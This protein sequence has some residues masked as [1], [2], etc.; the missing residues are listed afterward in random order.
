[1]KC[2]ARLSHFFCNVQVSSTLS[3]IRSDFQFFVMIVIDF[4]PTPTTQPHPTLNR[5]GQGLGTHP[6]WCLQGW[7]IPIGWRGASWT[8][9]HLWLQAF[10]QWAWTGQAISKY[11]NMSSKVL[12]N[13][14]TLIWFF[15][16]A[17]CV[18]SYFQELLLKR[19]CSLL[20]VAINA[21][22]DPL[23]S[24]SVYQCTWNCQIR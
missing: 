24:M 2:I 3:S 11:M 20:Q 8:L 18:T 17:C 15:T 6:T 14:H 16:G 22:L 1:M 12:Q 4:T 19:L 5:G 21:W 23:T 10:T 9:D 7:P 13:A